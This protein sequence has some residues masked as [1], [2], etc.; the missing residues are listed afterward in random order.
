MS[1]S[2]HKQRTDGE[3]LTAVFAEHWSTY[4]LD[5]SVLTHH[6]DQPGAL[7]QQAPQQKGFIFYLKPDLLQFNQVTDLIKK[8][9]S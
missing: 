4:Q 5:T 2:D 1:E 6:S 8:T 9:T 3:P 7:S